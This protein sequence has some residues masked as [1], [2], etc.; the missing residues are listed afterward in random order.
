M[1]AYCS[2]C[3]HCKCNNANRFRSVCSRV[4]P[5]VPFPQMTLSVGDVIFLSA[6]KDRSLFHR[7][8][9][10]VDKVI[11]Q[12]FFHCKS[13]S[14]FFQKIILLGYFM[15]S[16]HTVSTWSLISRT[17]SKFISAYFT[18]FNPEVC[19]FFIL[20]IVKIRMYDT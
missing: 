5:I 16:L 20:H 19:K 2:T 10:F 6:S 12:L 3:N 15:Y 8:T 11:A 14:V 4:F 7:F 18:V 1:P 9:F 13:I 17:L